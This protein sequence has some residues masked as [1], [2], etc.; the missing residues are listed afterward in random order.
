MGTTVTLFLNAVVAAAGLIGVP[1]LTE[2]QD[3]YPSRLIKIVVPFSAGTSVD[4]L[5]RL[6]A[7]KLSSRWGQPVIVEN[8][9]GAS[10][11]IGAEAVA[12]ADP[13]G[14]TLLGSPPPPL[15]INQYL[16]PKLAFDPHAF[17]GVTVLATVPNVLV[18]SPRV[19][20]ANIQELISYATANPDKLSYASPGLGTT[21]QLTAEWLKAL[22][23]IRILHVPYKGG[24]PALADLLGGQ[25]DMMFANLGDVLPYIRTGKLNALAVCSEGRF[26][27]LPN[28]PS[29]S[30]RFPGFISVAWYAIVAPPKTPPEIVAKLSS[31]ISET[32]RLP[33]IAARLND[34]AAT[35]VGNTPGETAAFMQE[36]ARRWRKVIA[37][38]GVRLD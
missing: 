2:A 31:A 5:P 36:E 27:A 18:I 20:V 29:L 14:Y 19:P 37:I 6:V 3:H 38:T 32:L 16:Y 24:A 35:P 25:V 11:N 9:A 12:R 1:R 34:L 10:G 17:V 30:E 7:E 23:G 13:D 21:P 22:T 15:V 8:R 4:L 26:A 28:V 33:D